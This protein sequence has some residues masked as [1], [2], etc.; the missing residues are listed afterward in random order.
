MQSDNDRT[1]SYANSQ[2]RYN[3]VAEE[4]PQFQLRGFAGENSPERPKPG[5]LPS[6]DGEADYR[7]DL[8]Q[9]RNIMKAYNATESEAMITEKTGDD[10][11][12]M[13]SQNMTSPDELAERQRVYRQQSS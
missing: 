3:K 6:Q 10:E 11:S 8:E 1:D 9:L 7:N 12:G 4:T 13:H 5:F 2:N